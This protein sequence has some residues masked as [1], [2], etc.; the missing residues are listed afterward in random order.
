MTEI[1][2]RGVGAAVAREVTIALGGRVVV[3]STN[4]KGSSFAFHFPARAIEG[5]AGG[6]LPSRFPGRAA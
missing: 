4:G 3:N 2:G 5:L 6:P 1:S